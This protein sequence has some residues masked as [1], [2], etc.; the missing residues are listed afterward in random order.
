MA[1]IDI[2]GLTTS[3]A[4]F[5]NTIRV[6]EDEMKYAPMDGRQVTATIAEL[7]PPA[8]L[9]ASELLELPLLHRQI[10]AWLDKRGPNLTQ[11]SSLLVL[12]PLA[13]SLYDEAEDRE[14]V[15]EFARKVMVEN[16][17]G[18][19]TNDLSQTPQPFS[20]SSSTIRSSD[21]GSSIAH[22][23][24]MRFKDEKS[25]FSCSIGQFFQDY[26]SDYLQA[27]RDYDLSPT[28]KLQS[29]HNIFTGDA[30]RY[31]CDRVAGYASGFIQAVDMIKDE[32]N[33]PVRQD[34]CKNC[35]S[36]MRV[37]RFVK[38]GV[39]VSEAP[40]KVYMAITKLGPQVS[41]SRRGESHRVEFLR[42]ALIVYDWAVELLSRIATR[43]ISFQQLYGELESALHLS[44]E[45]EAAL[46]RDQVAGFATV[47]EE[48]PGIMYQSEGRY[49]DRHNSL[50][51]RNW[52]SN[53]RQD[54]RTKG[55]TDPL[56]LMGYFNFEDPHHVLSDCKK[57][58]NL[59]RATKNRLEYY[60]KKRQTQNA[61]PQVLYELCSQLQSEKEHNSDTKVMPA[62][63]Q[64]EGLTEDYDN[65]LALSIF[66]VASDVV[67]NTQEPAQSRYDKLIDEG[68]YACSSQEQQDF[69]KQSSVE[70]NTACIDCGSQ[71]SVVGEPQV[72]AFCQDMG[73]HYVLD[74]SGQPRRFKF[75]DCA[76]NRKR[77]LEFR[78]PVGQNYLVSIIAN[79]VGIDVPLLLGV[80]ILES[81]KHLIDVT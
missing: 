52:N 25:K 66:G 62:T 42:T 61:T 48:V 32:Y 17:R 50:S 22:K 69:T 18:R 67:E 47:K 45:I 43:L 1:P 5:I 77:T 6:L 36:A 21:V 71:G 11:H 57:P 81:Y 51:T 38:D 76:Q 2:T 8:V 41:Q 13:T 30:K 79:V 7:F 60:S 4:G 73:I 24:A 40:G 49:L 31:Y 10:R 39:E 72:K 64:N 75:G 28:Q 33:S 37:A 59:A 74:I 15:E 29:M 46:I 14:V 54:A 34:R 27:G 20:A 12:L 44:K 55:R 53:Q 16:R 80:D 9:F 65:A 35:F 23:I 78:V 68:I 63:E 56:I 70:F 19:D 26:I 3:Q 58:V